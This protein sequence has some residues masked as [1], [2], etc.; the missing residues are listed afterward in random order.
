MVFFEWDSVYVAKMSVPYVN[1][2]SKS[3]RD[4]FEW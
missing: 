3:Q 1:L 2:I 4:G